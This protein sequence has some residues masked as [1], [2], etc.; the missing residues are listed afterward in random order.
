MNINSLYLTE[1]DCIKFILNDL[2]YYYII[3][4]RGDIVI[5]YGM[6]KAALESFIKE[7]KNKFLYSSLSQVTEKWFIDTQLQGWYLIPKRYDFPFGE[8][9]EDYLKNQ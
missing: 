2:K 6:K 4:G 3:S 7:R 5:T 1:A 8:S 9:L